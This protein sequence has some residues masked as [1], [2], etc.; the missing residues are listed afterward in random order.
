MISF[1][2][3]VFLFGAAIQE[4]QPPASQAR[5]VGLHDLPKDIALPFRD[6]GFTVVAVTFVNQGA[7][8]VTIDTQKIRVLGPKN[9]PLVAAS[10]SEVTPKMVKS[11]ARGPNLHAGGTGG[12]Y[13][14]GYGRPIQPG[15]VVGGGNGTGVIDLARVEQLKATIEKYQLKTTDVRAGEKVEGYLYLKTDEDPDKLKGT[16]ILLTDDVTLT[17]E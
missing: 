14:P 16:R 7:Q 3:L 2:L 1:L 17:V 10:S 6:N 11:G 12:V 9:K 8:T 13:R 5:M 4:G 15:V